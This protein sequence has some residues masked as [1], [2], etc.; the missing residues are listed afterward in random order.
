MGEGVLKSSPG[1]Q[2]GRRSG[3]PPEAGQGAERD[4]SQDASR[5]PVCGGAR[6]VG[7][8]EDPGVIKKCKVA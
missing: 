4:D 1:Q 6:A 8:D 2:A 7:P 3:E 5:L